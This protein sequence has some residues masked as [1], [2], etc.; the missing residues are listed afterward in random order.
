MGHNVRNSE[1][2]RNLLNTRV[3][4]LITAGWVFDITCSSCR[5]VRQVKLLAL[6]AQHGPRTIGEV[7]E[8]MRCTVCRNEPNLVVIRN[9]LFRV[10]LVEPGAID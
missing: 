1:R 10:T 7:V 6:G 8:R 3:A 2:R 5:D 4:S 9:R